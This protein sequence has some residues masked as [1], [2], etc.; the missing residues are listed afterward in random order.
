MLR[1]SAKV[2][3]IVLGICAWILITA[4]VHAVRVLAGWPWLTPQLDGDPGM[5]LATSM[6]FIAVSVCL[7]L[8]VR[9]QR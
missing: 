3:R 6:C 5:A 7:I 4:I 8:L 1:D 2:R 9:I